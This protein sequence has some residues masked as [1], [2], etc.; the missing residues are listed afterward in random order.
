M[1][2]ETSEDKVACWSQCKSTEGCTW[3]SFDINHQTCLS[4]KDCPEIEADPQFVSGQKECDYGEYCVCC[5][6]FKEVKYF[7]ILFPL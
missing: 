2:S 1:L 7:Y 5:T 4:F 6:F 3:F